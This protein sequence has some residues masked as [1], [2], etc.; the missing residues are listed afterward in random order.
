MANAKSNLTYRQRQALAT[1]KLIVDSAR[2][3]FLEQGYGNT[4][5]EAI[6]VR[7]GVAVS[8]VYSV[9]GSKR[10][11][12]RAIREAWHHESQQRDIYREARQQS[13]PKRRLELAARATRRQWE[14]G[15][16]MLTIYR[17][18]AATDQE[19]AA[20][21]KE[22]LRGRRAALDRFI[23]EMAPALRA[24]LSS[25]QAAAIFFALTLP[26]V[27]EN[28]VRGAGWSPNQYEAWLAAI[29][30]QQLLP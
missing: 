14:T 11:I 6:S 29:L 12:L 9:F 30:L 22:A 19:A 20:E 24:D 10:G 5:I 18:A 16:A 7:A 13:D 15:A 8:T 3:L 23:N 28:L 2:D 25:E 1:Q 4:T 17:G 27:Y 26:E 21:L